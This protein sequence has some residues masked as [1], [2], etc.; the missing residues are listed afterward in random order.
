[1]GSPVCLLTISW[2]L[3]TKQ[4]LLWLWCLCWKDCFGFFRFHSRH[5]LFHQSVLLRAFANQFHRRWTGLLIILFTW[6]KSWSPCDFRLSGFLWWVNVLAMW[7]APHALSCL[8]TACS[9]LPWTAEDFEVI[10]LQG[11]G[12]CPLCCVLKIYLNSVLNSSEFHPGSFGTLETTVNICTR[13]GFLYQR[14]QPGFLYQV[15]GG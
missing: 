11:D 14:T 13:P 7:R 3:L 12:R 4:R 1:M 8:E 2:W 15:G 9:P 6:A 5:C 10:H